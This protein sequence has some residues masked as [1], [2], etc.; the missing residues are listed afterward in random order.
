MR[1]KQ[2]HEAL[3]VWL[4]QVAPRSTGYEVDPFD[5]QTLRETLAIF[6]AD[7]EAR[8]ELQSVEGDLPSKEPWTSVTMS[9][10]LVMHL[11]DLY[12]AY[13]HPIHMLFD[14]TGFRRDYQNS[15][16][17]HCSRPLLNA[18]CAMACFIYEM[19]EDQQELTP[20]QKSLKIAMMGRAFINEA[21]E[22]L[23]NLSHYDDLT[24]VQTFAVLFLVELSSGRATTA[25]SYLKIALEGLV[26]VKDSPQTAHAK[27]LSLMGLQVLRT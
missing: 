4:H 2:S 23:L 14:E 11:L 16:V 27:E 18:V 20:L 13:V 25:I 22:T 17:I 19:S 3:A 15:C 10:R 5:A 6:E 8:G 12:F 21:K 7:C 9:S 1:D 24:T 26:A